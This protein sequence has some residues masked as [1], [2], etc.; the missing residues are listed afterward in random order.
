M[1]P[2]PLTQSHAGIWGSGLSHTLESG[3]VASGRQSPQEGA[4]APGKPPSLPHSTAPSS[5]LTALMPRW[6]SRIR[7]AG[8]HAWVQLEWTLGRKQTLSLPRPPANLAAP[9][10]S[11][12]EED[13]SSYP[14]SRTPVPPSPE[15]DTSTPTPMA[16]QVPGSFLTAL[17]TG[18]RSV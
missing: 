16:G 7:L 4:A 18:C 6:G 10:K 1:L 17:L 14:Q 3:G 11:P 13:T 12:P 2:P 5:K 8:P 15:Q 9:I